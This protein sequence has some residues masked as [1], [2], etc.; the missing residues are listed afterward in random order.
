MPLKLESFF[1]GLRKYMRK[2]AAC[3]IRL[4]WQ[5]SLFPP[6]SPVPTP[7]TDFLLFIFSFI[8]FLL[9]FCNMILYFLVSQEYIDFDIAHFPRI[10]DVCFKLLTL[11][12]GED[13]Q[14]TI[15]EPC[16]HSVYDVATACRSSCFLHFF[17]I[18]FHV[19]HSSNFRLLV[20]KSLMLC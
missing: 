10:R 11:M 3:H 17:Q 16:H 12:S 19:K 18:H 6:P 2:K 9:F 5:A 20:E 8:C 1:F 13:I 15:E 7:V 14:F 4:L